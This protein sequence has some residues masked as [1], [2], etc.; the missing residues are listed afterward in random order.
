MVQYYFGSKQGL[1]A[2]MLQ[3]AIAPLRAQVQA[4]LMDMGRELGRSAAGTSMA[5]PGRRIR[6]VMSTAVCRRSS[7]ICSRRS[8]RSTATAVCQR[9]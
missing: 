4:M 3:D 8:T 7:T 5:G 9:R 2:A 1:Y 6:W